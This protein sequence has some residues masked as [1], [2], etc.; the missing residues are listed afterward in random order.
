MQYREIKAS[1]VFTFLQVLS[2]YIKQ[3]FAYTIDE[4]AK[5]SYN[6]TTSRRCYYE[7]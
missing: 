6:M 3:V 4:V 2:R 5:L 1:G 7:S